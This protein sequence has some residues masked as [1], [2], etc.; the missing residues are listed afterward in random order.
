MKQTVAYLEH[1]TT[2]KSMSYNFMSFLRQ[3]FS[4]YALKGLTNFGFPSEMLLVQQHAI[5]QNITNQNQSRHY[6][7]I[8]S[9]S[10]L[11]EE[12]QTFIIDF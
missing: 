3:I 9:R 10:D 7:K 11:L 8:S 6:N 5:R 12:F 2:V 4:F 1:Q